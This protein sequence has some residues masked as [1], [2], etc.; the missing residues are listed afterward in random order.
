[1]GTIKFIYDN[2]ESSVGPVQKIVLET[3]VVEKTV[4]HRADGSNMPWIKKMKDIKRRFI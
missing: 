3:K 1:M 2:S 4:H